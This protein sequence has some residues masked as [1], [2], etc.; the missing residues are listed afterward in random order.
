MKPEY[1]FGAGPIPRNEKS[2]QDG[3]KSS[4]MRG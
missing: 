2:G 3:K 4:K 1:P